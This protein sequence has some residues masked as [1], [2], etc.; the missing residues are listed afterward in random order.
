M[1]KKQT[2]QVRLRALRAPKLAGAQ[3]A[4][5]R[6]NRHEDETDGREMT[7]IGKV[8]EPIGID[9]RKRAGQLLIGL[10]MVD[11]N[12]IEAKLARLQKR[13][14]AR[15]SAVDRHEQACPLRRKRLDRFDIRSI[16]FEQPVRNVDDRAP[17]AMNEIAPQ[18]GC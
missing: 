17:A 11:D 18:H 7:E 2:K 16:T 15:R 1:K 10:M 4:V 5:E 9:E 14:M 8:I 13:S 12:D 6:N 3:L